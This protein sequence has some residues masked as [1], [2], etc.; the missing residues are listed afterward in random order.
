MSTHDDLN[1]LKF[2]ILNS[3]R[4]FILCGRNSYFKSKANILINKLIIKKK[5]YTYFKK[6]FYPD[7]KEIKIIAKKIKSFSPDL[8]LAV[9]GGTVIDC[10]KVASIMNFRSNSIIYKRRSLKKKLIA[11][12]LTSGSGAEVTSTSVI[13]VNKIKHSIE[14]N[15]IKPDECI[16]LPELIINAPKKVKGASIFDCIAQSVESIFS[17]RSNK[18]SLFYAVRSLRISLKYYLSYYRKPTLNNSRNML[19]AANYAGK[20]IDISRTIASH[21]FSYPF[22]SLM[23]IEHGKAVAI[24]FVNVLK[25]NFEYQS[26]SLSKFLLSSRYKLLYKLTGAKNI[27]QLSL[28]FEKIIENLNINLRSQ[29]FRHAIDTNFEK[30]TQGIN[31]KRLMNNPVKIDKSSFRNIIYE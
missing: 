25:F 14:N 7:I 11:I 16:L 3:N 13:Y 24:T 6:F 21:A 17:L 18:K 22:T 8:I 5:T 10:A 1:R 30:I 20:A 28:I 19:T 2:F 26:K 23:G 9:G 31:K 29:K 4:I 27:E 15:F 12:P